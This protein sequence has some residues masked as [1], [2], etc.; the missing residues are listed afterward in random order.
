[1]E[2]NKPL[3]SVIMPAYNA[4]RFIE[5]AVRSVMSQT[6]TDWELLI[7]DDGSK[8]TTAAIAAK[9]ASEDT[10][11]RFLPNE[12]NMGVAKTRNR[13]L[14]LCRGQYVALLDSDDIWLPEKLEKQLALAEKTG[15]DLIY[16]SYGIMDEHGAK[17]RQDYLVSDRATMKS[18]LRENIIG[19]STVLLSRQVVDRYRFEERFYHEDY[20]LWLTLLQE[21]YQAAGCVEP[22]VKWRLIENSRSFD[23][24]KSAKNRWRIYRQ[25]LKLPILTSA[26][27][28]A[29]YTVAGFRKYLFRR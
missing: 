14:D 1:M 6:V 29:G 18:L 3:V 15:A 12:A 27:Y 19:C 10:R 8:D 2:T 20:V 26:W 7:L 5:A 17:A 21:G 13:G 24:R 25:Y 16:C 11:I 22:L 23:K 9:L 28:F 4:E